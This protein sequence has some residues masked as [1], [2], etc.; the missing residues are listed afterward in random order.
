[1]A[2]V[3]SILP[4]DLIIEVFGVISFR[5]ERY[6]E[7]LDVLSSNDAC[8]KDI[9]IQTGVKVLLM[10]HNYGDGLVERNGCF[11][12][13][14]VPEP[15]LLKEMWYSRGPTTASQGEGAILAVSGDPSHSVR[16]WYY[17]A[18]RMLDGRS[19]GKFVDDVPDL[20]W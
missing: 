2:G 11:A 19:Y 7:K 20:A 9:R 3:F 10:G 5:G 13:K 16:S 18:G 14:V 1:V 12:C 15:L 17:S 8:V 6:I 4:A